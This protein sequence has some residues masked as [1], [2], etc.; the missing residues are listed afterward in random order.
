MKRKPYDSDLTD[1][2]WKLIE[3]MLPPSKR[4]GRRRAYLREIINDVIYACMTPAK[5]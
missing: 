3:P 2:Q 1:S 5:K 4:R